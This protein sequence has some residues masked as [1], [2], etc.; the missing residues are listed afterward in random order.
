VSC[1]AVRSRFSAFIDGDVGAEERRALGVHLG[2]CA[3]CAAEL[4]ALETALSAL[5]EL[6]HVDAGNVAAAVRDRIELERRGPG[7][8]LLFRPAWKARPLLGQSLVQGALVF[9]TVLSVMLSLGRPWRGVD[10][11]DA[12]LSRWETRLPPSG[13][14]GN[15]LF[16]S[17]GVSV[18][19]VRARGQAPEPFL[20][21]EGEG[22][23]FLETVVARD[24]SVSAVT[25]IEGDLQEA[26]A[27]ADALRLE[28]FEPSR[29]GGRPVAVSL[30]RLF[31][32]TEVRAGRS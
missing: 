10:P 12:T 9:T 27:L 13:T 23:V 18:P 19:Q 7:L 26:R 16:P 22:S 1:A 5:H 28:R 14:E 29:V 11:V 20:S 31:S 6:P 30:Y 21:P 8:Q 24:G 15:P 3:A 25:L 4:S 32:R 2:G 17:A